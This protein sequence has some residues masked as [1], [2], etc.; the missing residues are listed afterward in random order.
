MYTA[1]AI[2]GD[3]GDLRPAQEKIDVDV[4]G[5]ADFDAGEGA[6]NFFEEDISPGGLGTT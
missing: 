6:S 2:L 4:T 5:V 3:V 1:T